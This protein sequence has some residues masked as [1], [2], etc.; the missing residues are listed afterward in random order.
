MSKSNSHEA[1][2]PQLSQPV[3]PATLLALEPLTRVEI[4]AL[5][6]KKK[7]ISDYYRKVLASKA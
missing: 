4:D 2:S 7:S 3:K 5:R 1:L 6:Q